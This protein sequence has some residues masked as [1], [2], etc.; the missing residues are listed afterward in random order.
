[1]TSSNGLVAQVEKLVTAELVKRRKCKPESGMDVAAWN[2]ANPQHPKDARGRWSDNPVGQA[3]AGAYARV[4]AVHGNEWVGLADLREEIGG[5]FTR[6]EVDAELRRLGAGNGDPSIRIE[7][8][9]NQKTLSMRDRMAA[10]SMGGGD[11]HVIS[12]EGDLSAPSKKPNKRHEDFLPGLADSPFSPGAEPWRAYRANLTRQLVESNSGLSE[13]DDDELERAQKAAMEFSRAAE[14]EL[15]RRKGEALN[16]P[17]PKKK[18]RAT[19][20]LTAKPQ[21]DYASIA[22]RARQA[23]TDEDARAALAGLTIPQLRELGEMVDF[24]PMAKERKEQVVGRLAQLLGGGRRA[25][26]GDR[27]R[28]IYD[29]L[30]S[31]PE[32]WVNIA[33]IRERLGDMSRA[34][35]DELLR[36]LEQRPDVN[37]VPL[38]NVKVL[39]E[40]T[41]SGSVRIG[42]QDKHFIAMGLGEPMKPREKPATARLSSKPKQETDFANMTRAEKLKRPDVTREEV[43]AALKD[44]KLAELRA[45]AKELRNHGAPVSTSGTRK[46]QIK[47]DIIDG[48][49]GPKERARA[50]PKSDAQIRQG[51][52][53]AY[54]KLAQRQG[55]LVSLV[56]LRHELSDIPRA[57]L[58]RLLKEMDRARVFHLDPDSNRKA[59]PREAHEAALS[60]GG[61]DKHFISMSR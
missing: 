60:I 11:L 15:F 35:Q 40:R 28:S 17:A 54:A 50:M 46:D 2:A 9:T 5:W 53:D 6:N 39:S 56:K 21:P 24:K 18:P 37:I 48:L 22:D 25:A 44:M 38:A 55:D 8:E 7:E 10:L 36:E 12:I 52:I 49:I 47:G 33:D 57:D 30:A 20:R 43:E 32:A 41:Q 14:M 1:M 42:G 34:D 27:V 31:E 26:T 23:K 3:I 61:E 16:P 29:E 19:A 45:L 4:R 59:L 58:D 13:W 51:I